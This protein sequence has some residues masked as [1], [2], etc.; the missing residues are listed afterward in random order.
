MVAFI[1]ATLVILGLTVLAFWFGVRSRYP[2]K[3]TASG[4]R[5]LLLARAEGRLTTEEF[6]RQ[7][8]ALHAS[9]L[10]APRVPAVQWYVFLLPFAIASAM[11]CLY[12]WV[13]VPQSSSLPAS[14]VVP[15]NKDGASK[16]P[17]NE[18]Q[19]LAQRLR[20][21]LTGNAD[22]VPGRPT[23]NAMADRPGG[24][25]GVMTKRLADRLQ[26]EPNDGS[27]WALL[28]R[29]YVELRRYKEAD[30]AFATW[31]G[32]SPPNATSLADWADAHVIANDRKWDKQALDLVEKALSMDPKHLKAL[33]L[34]GSAAFSSGNY[35]QAAAYWTRMKAAAAPGSMEAKEA[36]MNLNEARA[37][38]A[39][40]NTQPAPANQ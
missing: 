39:G 18:M 35:K 2:G 7:Q 28:A 8:A 15:R 4:L 16:L 11:A 31:A 21:N 38:L 3:D 32:L 6:E 24:D 13:E 5:K 12:A 1:I 10:E 33:A 17:R 25:L 22:S 34:A 27:G 20:E 14:S 30:E 36:D 29:S 9:A 19:D 40:K 23:G 26:R 37:R